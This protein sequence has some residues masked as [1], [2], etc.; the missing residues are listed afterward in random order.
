MDQ[1][2]H[3]TKRGEIGAGISLGF[4]HSDKGDGL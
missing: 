2:F 1:A 3:G 4:C